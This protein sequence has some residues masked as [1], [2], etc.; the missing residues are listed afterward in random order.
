LGN[1]TSAPDTLITS[2]RFSATLSTVTHKQGPWT[3]V[4]MSEIKDDEIWQRA[5]E[6]DGES[7]AILFDKHHPRVFG[8]ALRLTSNRHDAEDVVA[9]AFLELWRRRLDVRVVEGSIAPWLLVTTTNCSLNLRRSL[10]RHRLFISKL[11]REEPTVEG[12]EET[13][14]S[15]GDLDLDP[16]LSTTI[17]SMSKLD[18]Q[19][20]AL[21]AFNDYSLRVAAETLGIS[22]QAARSRW[23]RIRRKLSKIEISHPA[24]HALET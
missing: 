19:L 4:G 6:G 11:P 22:E 9:A 8:H 12:A 13:A 20:L 7:F 5:I 17:K 14:L 18:Q 24:F 10:R 2:S 16:L 21:V 3:L 23:Q 15:R 1:L